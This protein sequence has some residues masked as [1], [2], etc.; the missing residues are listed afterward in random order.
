MGELI[1]VEQSGFK[2]IVWW[3]NYWTFNTQ[4]LVSFEFLFRYKK[5]LKYYFSA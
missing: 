4:Y 2:L 1:D 5:A 3:A